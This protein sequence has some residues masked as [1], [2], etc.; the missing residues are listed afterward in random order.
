MALFTISFLGGSSFRGDL[1]CDHSVQQYNY[2][3]MTPFYIAVCHCAEMMIRRHFILSFD[4]IFFAAAFC[5]TLQVNH[6]TGKILGSC[7]IV[8]ESPDP[9]FESKREHNRIVN[10]AQ[11]VKKHYDQ[12]KTNFT[13]TGVDLDK[14]IEAFLD[15]GLPTE[16]E[17]TA[18]I[19]EK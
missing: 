5:L 12:L 11:I 10:S 18:V 7:T 1:G 16:K 6:G 9:N 19:E 2:I 15:K 3:R 14:L 4:D 17:T 13:S 8:F